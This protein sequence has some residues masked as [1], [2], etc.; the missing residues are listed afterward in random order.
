MR[1][2]I[3]FGAEFD[4]KWYDEVIEGCALLPDLDMLPAG[5]LTEIGEKV[6]PTTILSGL[7]DLLHLL[8]LS[9][10]NCILS[11]AGHKLIRRT[12]TKSKLS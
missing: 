5:D 8:K 9:Y 7:Y 10:C 11:I 2:N 6:T 1:D 4:Q 12:K 3:L